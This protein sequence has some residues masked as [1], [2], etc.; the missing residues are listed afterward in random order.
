MFF[1]FLVVVARHHHSNPL[2]EQFRAQFATLH[3]VT[4]M[5]A[6]RHNF[7]VYKPICRTVLEEERKKSA[8]AQQSKGINSAPL[9]TQAQEGTTFLF[10][11][12]FPPE[13]HIPTP[14]RRCHT[15]EIDVKPDIIESEAMQGRIGTG[16]H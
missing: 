15:R 1:L 13:E 5:L 9:T 12:L 4:A 10:F 16:N 3:Y 14:N 6:W 11:L 2:V 7:L 8:T